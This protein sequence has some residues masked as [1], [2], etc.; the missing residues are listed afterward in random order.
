MLQIR[1]EGGWVLFEEGIELGQDESG[2]VH[3][4][5][6]WSNGRVVELE[7]SE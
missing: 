4:K 6:E 1:D 2:W 5:K 7:L 3:E